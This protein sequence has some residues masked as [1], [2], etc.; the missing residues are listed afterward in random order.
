MFSNVEGAADGWHGGR[1]G[2]ADRGDRRH[3]AGG[4]LG[5]SAATLTAIGTYG[6]LA[7]GVLSMAA[8]AT[9]PGFSAEGSASTFATNPQSGLPYAI[10]R[11]RMSGLR[12]YARTYDG[13]K[14]QSK[15]DILAFVAMLSIA[16][17]IH[18]I[19][20]FTADNELVT[21]APNGDAN[22]RFYRYMAQ[23]LS[24]GNSPSTALALQ[25][26]GKPFPDWTSSHKLNGIAHAQWAMRF[27]T[28]GDLYG[29]GAPEPAWV[30]K[31]VKVYDPRK[32][33]TYPGGSGSHRALDEATYEWSDNPGLHA[34]TWALGRWQNGRR[35]CGIG[36]PVA[37]IR[38]AEFV[39]CAN[40]CDANGWRVGGVEWTTDSKWDTLKRM[41]QAGG[42]IPTQTGAMIGCLVSTP[43]TAIATIESRH[44]H[45]GLSIAA[46][47]SRRDRFNTVIPR[48]VDEDSDWAVISGTAVTEP[49]YVTADKGQRT[50]EID[51]PLV[52]VFSGEEATQPGQLAAYAIV[53]SREAGPFTWTTGPEWIGLKT[54]DVVYLNV[55]EEGL[56]N[57]PILI[58]RR[59]PD[60]ATG[61]VSFSGETETYSKHAYAL[62]QSTTPPP[63]FSLSAPDL[64]PAAPEA[65]NWSVSGA[66]SGEG[67]PALLVTGQSEMP[68]A[69]SIIIDYRKSGDEAWISSAILSAVGPV[70]HTVAPL[71]SETAYDVRI[72]YRVGTIDGNTTIFTNVVT[73]LGKLTIIEGQQSDVAAELAQLETDTAQAL[74]D[75]AA[76]ETLI[77]QIQGSV[78]ADI[79]A[80]TAE[81]GTVTADLSALTAEVTAAG[82]AIDTIETTLGQQGASI[83]SLQTTVNNQAGTL[84][85]HTSQISTANANISTNASAITTANTNIANLT[86]RVGSAESS[87]TS[88]ATA[89]TNLTGRTA[90]LEGTV[91]SQG[92]SITSLQTATSTLNGSVATLTTKVTAANPNL[93]PGGGF[94]N[95]LTGWWLG[96]FAWTWAV[97]DGFGWGRYVGSGNSFTGQHRFIGSPV[98]AV[99]GSQQYAFSGDTHAQ[100]SGN[101][102]VY[103]TVVWFTAAQQYI[104]ETA[105]PARIFAHTFSSDGSGRSALAFSATSPSNAAFASVRISFDASAGG[106]FTQCNARQ[107]KAERGSLAT[108]WSNEAS[109]T[110]SFTAI[111]TLDTQF[112]QLSTTVSTQGASI[113]QNATALTNLTGRTATLETTV[114]TQGA[115]I[116]SL[117]TT[118]STLQGNVATLSTQVSAGNPNLMSGFENG[119]T[120]WYLGGHSWVW[121]VVD[122]FGWGRYV[123]SNSQFSGAR[124]V[125]TSPVFG[126]SGSQPYTVTADTHAQWTGVASVYLIFAWLDVNQQYISEVAGP[127]RNTAHTFSS[128]GSGRNALKLTATS[129]SNARFAAVYVAFNAT[130][131]GTFTE[132]N[133]RQIKAERGSVATAYTSEASVTQAFSTLSTLTTQYASLS[134]TVSTQGV[135]ITSQQ[136]AITTI[137]GNITTLFG[138]W[139]VEIDVNGYGSGFSLNNNGSRS[140][141]IWRVDKFAIGAPG[142]TTDYPF[143]VVGSTTYLKNAKIQNAA[144]DTLKIAGNSIVVP[145]NQTAADITVS[146]GST[147]I[148]MPSFFT[149]GDGSG[150][151]AIIDFTCSTRSLADDRQI[152]FNMLVDTGNGAGYQ[153]VGDT[154][155][156]T[157]SDSGVGTDFKLTAQIKKA[158]SA[159]QV[160][161]AISAQVQGYNTSGDSGTTGGSVVVRQPTL[162]ITG[163]KR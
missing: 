62:G 111:S 82:G 153:G 109:L 116:T 54:G 30:G 26:G 127:A 158:V 60:P 90:T 84:A 44:L 105:G 83:T 53:N 144:I 49:A 119:L 61:K 146:G 121:N 113:T 102:S 99:S 110:Q 72:A 140:D 45:D 100:W 134:T 38:V 143:Q 21:F 101:A 154:I 58:T 115:S 9:A 8:Q 155:I 51:F 137:N 73:G 160:R 48:Y 135:T 91:S 104:S 11:T 65:T 79:N 114:S 16:G 156:G 27:D 47:K 117:Q 129:P 37:N 126:I 76:A 64:K 145:Y 23:D 136:T 3:G 6:S 66:T 122:G 69:D 34:L 162:V 10:G 59:A 31:W 92:A 46:T 152:V 88:S 141:A 57:Q 15:H 70:S 81:V 2:C 63:P 95:G 98:F 35:V 138:R 106:T 94:E 55:P 50:K 132:M 75:I 14:Q 24:L 22:G 161:V 78:T 128:D 150:G 4:V 124:R 7:A 89:I 36:A 68:S 131:G 17:P 32:D 77:T 42:A 87:I 118:T 71:E 151:T 108:V 159:A 19:E 39:E 52:Q 43:R 139:G 41:L 85:T 40:V 112:S 163:G 18:S 67:F 12:V 5:V 96:G 147:V 103:L 107:V 130:G 28:D 20:K 86:T 80:L 120:G 13:F 125:I 123:G 133:V 25:F 1:R 142:A 74:I 93:L 149:V 56:V 148:E 33:S 97:N 29:A 157:R